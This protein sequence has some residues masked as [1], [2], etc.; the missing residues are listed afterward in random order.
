M[1][2]ASRKPRRHFSVKDRDVDGEERW[3]TFGIVSG[4]LLL[5]VVHTLREDDDDDS[6]EVIRIISARPANSKERRRYE[7]EDRS[8]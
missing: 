7:D 3:Q 5:M 1:A 2:S 8:I 6:V 4:L